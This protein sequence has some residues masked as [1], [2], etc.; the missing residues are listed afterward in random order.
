MIDNRDVIIE[1]ISNDHKTVISNFTTYE[2]D[3][4]D[5][6]VESAL[7][8]QNDRI[9]K[10][11]LLFYRN[12]LVGYVTLLCDSLRVEGELRVR[13]KTKNIHY[14]SLPA[15]KIGR[16][17]VDDNYLRQGFGTRLLELAYAYSKKVS[18]NYCGC[19]FLIL[20]AKRTKDKSK[21]SLYFY[22]KLNF[23]I[24]KEREKGTTPMYL[25]IVLD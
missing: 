15:I 24:L 5:F 14:K 9:S 13:L 17:A 6:L 12:N 22:K 7:S 11:F 10:T 21:D 16:L 3:L 20:D 4:K 25:D 1:P 19:R 8:N 18:D 23:H 2:S